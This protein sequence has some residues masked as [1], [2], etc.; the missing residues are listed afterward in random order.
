VFKQALGDFAKSA[1]DGLLKLPSKW[2]ERLT[3]VADRAPWRR[4]S[5]PPKTWTDAGLQR[6]LI[7]E[8]HATLGEIAGTVLGIESGGGS[9]GN[10]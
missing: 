8:R 4:G 1:I 6:S 10:M 9:G 7:G 3:P 2:R 5:G